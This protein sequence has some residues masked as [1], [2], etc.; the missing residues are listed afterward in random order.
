MARK[1]QLK[2]ALPVRDVN[3][4]KEDD[5]KILFMQLIKPWMVMS[6]I[7]RDYGIDAIVGMTKPIARSQQQ[8]VTGK[9]FSVQ[10]KSSTEND[11]DKKSFSLSIPI[12]KINYWMQ[13]FEPVLLV[14]VDLNNSA[15]YYRWIDEELILQ[16]FIINENWIGQ[17]SVSI[18]FDKNL[19][20]TPKSLNVIED[21]VLKWKRSSQT[22][23]TPGNYFKFSNDAHQY[24]LMI[25]E[26][27]QQFGMNFLD[28]EIEEL[29]KDVS[30]SI[31]TIAIIG[32]S[33]VGKS[34]LINAL[35]QK[36]VSPV[37]L[38]PTTGIP[39]TIFPRDKNE[40]IVTFKD[41]TT[42]TGDV[43][44]DFLREYIAQDKNP[45]NEKGVKLVQVSIINTLLERGFALCDVPGLDD[46]DPIIKNIAKT[47]IYNVNAIVY[48]ISVGTY[49]QGEFK[50]TDQNIS[51][52]HDLRARMD[53]VFLVFNKV[54]A[55]KSRELKDVKEYIDR[56]LKT[57]GVL[58]FLAHPPI[59]ISSRESF[60]MRMKGKV[61]NNTVSQLEQVLWEYLINQN[62]TGLHKLLTQYANTLE[63]TA[64]LKNV[65]AIRLQQQTRRKELEKE[66][67][68]VRNEIASLRQ[69][70]REKRD[71]VYSSTQDYLVD[72]FSNVISHLR[73]ELQGSSPLPHQ[74][75]ILSFLE[76]EAYV[77]IS[78]VYEFLQ[79]QTYE[80]QSYVNS[81]IAEK[82]KQ[83]EI[84]LDDI[85]GTQKL[86]L[87]DISKYTSKVH[88]FFAENKRGY[89][90]ILESAFSWIGEKIEQLFTKLFDVFTSEAEIRQR[91]INK[92]V[93][94]A[95]SFYNQIQV[96]LLQNTSHFLNGVCFA[97]E[98]KSADRTNVYLGLLNKEVKEL[99]RS[100]S[101]LE[102]TKHTSFIAEIES[103]E[104]EIQT[105]YVHLE[106]YAS[107]VR[108]FSKREEQSKRKVRVTKSIRK[109]FPAKK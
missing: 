38:L 61:G 69:I 64:R 67:T 73:S 14:Y 92:I 58:D 79:S 35:L 78:D 46:A 53:R 60:N 33:R 5:S 8:I 43:S 97:I 95:Q 4:I 86:Q 1:K 31:F 65:V 34:T 3:H 52:L 66:I 28:P 50:I 57:Y 94:R 9:R 70:V 48:V 100:L 108:W 49:A 2:E 10:L 36:D 105:H 88:S 85:S 63:V 75:N 23:L 39:F 41:G 29:S 51:D 44:S 32:L 45:A 90:G 102:K 56:T 30:N 12:A 72:R 80:F 13:S 103:I 47:T 21:Y 22:L 81:W 107:G 11:F 15:A 62:K 74:K 55:L 37:G 25:K 16:L 40:T 42:R 84:N 106:E 24:S 7:E 89:F 83:V 99:N 104:K 93:N 71:D 76:N 6:W 101:D 18:K 77:I 17:Q 87:P 68:T 91:N 96:D 27:C 82:L 26:L 20:L 54:D 59:Y 98:D 19:T 109:S